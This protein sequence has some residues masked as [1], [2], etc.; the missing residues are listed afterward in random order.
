MLD[1]YITMQM[2]SIVAAAFS[3]EAVLKGRSLFKD[4]LG[5]AVASPLVTLV[6]DG[7]LADRLGSAPFDGEGVSCQRTVLVGAGDIEEFPL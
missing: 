4:K 2:M 7:T 1:P 6:D 5:E 3:G